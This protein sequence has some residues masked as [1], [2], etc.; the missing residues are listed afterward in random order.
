MIILQAG[1]KMAGMW[2]KAPPKRKQPASAPA[3]AAQAAGDADAALRAAQ[4]VPP[5]VLTAVVQN[6]HPRHVPVCAPFFAQT[7][8]AGSCEAG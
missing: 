7:D 6:V 5:Y 2:S 1:N 4:Q 3:A 8:W